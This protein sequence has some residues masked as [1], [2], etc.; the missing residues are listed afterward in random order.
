MSEKWQGVKP[1]ENSRTICD[2][3]WPDQFTGGI[4]EVT[5]VRFAGIKKYP[6]RKELYSMLSSD[7]NRK[8]C[9]IEDDN[10]LFDFLLNKKFTVLEQSKS[11]TCDKPV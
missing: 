9:L 2:S 5:R 11:K 3:S 10:V 1:W 4:H 8:T 6:A 7:R